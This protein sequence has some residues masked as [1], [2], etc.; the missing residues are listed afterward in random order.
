MQDV[1]VRDGYQKEVEDNFLPPLEAL[2]RQ[3]MVGV[4]LVITVD[5]THVL[6]VRFDGSWLVNFPLSMLTSPVTLLLDNQM[7][8][9]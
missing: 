6:V 1:C 2:L 5:T 8:E 7:N 3:H 4:Q 9:C